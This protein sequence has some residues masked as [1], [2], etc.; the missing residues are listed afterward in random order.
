[1]NLADAGPDESVLLGGAVC[2]GLSCLF[3]VS[4]IVLAIVLVRRSRKNRPGG[5]S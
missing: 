1:M 5:V 4:A 3:V 2:I